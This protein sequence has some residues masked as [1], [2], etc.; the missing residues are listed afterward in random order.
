M[1]ILYDNSETGKYASFPEL[2][3]QSHNVKAFFAGHTHRWLD[4]SSFNNDVPH[5]TLGG[6][7]YDANNFWLVELDGTAGSFKILDQGKAILNNSCAQ[8]WSYAGTPKPVPNAQD[9]GDCVSSFD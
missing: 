4:Q 7:R 8:T 6:T 2:L 5:F 9:H 1:R 3:D